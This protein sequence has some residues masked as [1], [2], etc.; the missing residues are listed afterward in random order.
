[1]PTLAGAFATLPPVKHNAI[2]LLLLMALL[3]QGL[4]IARPGTLTNAAVDLDHAMLHWVG[5]GHH[6]RGDSYHL[7]DSDESARHLVLD[8]AGV[9]ALPVEDS[10]H[11]PVV[12]S[13]SVTLDE[14]R[15]GPQPFLK[16]PLRP[17]RLIT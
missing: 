6:H 7:D 17:P 15:P 11:V 8:Q 4:A 3:W 12:G 14:A 5:E 10:L 16:G 1:M 2:M 13:D 9:S